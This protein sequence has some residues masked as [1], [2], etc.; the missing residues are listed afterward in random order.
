M[1]I[2][3]SSEIADK[4]MTTMQRLLQKL[5]HKYLDI[6]LIYAEQ[7]EI[8]KHLVQS[9][10]GSI[11]PKLCAILKIKNQAI[12][13]VPLLATRFEEAWPV[14]AYLTR[15]LR[16]KVSRINAQEPHRDSNQDGYGE[17][18]D[19]GSQDGSGQWLSDEETTE[20]QA[21]E[22]WDTQEGQRNDSQ[23]WGSHSRCPPPVRCRDGHIAHGTNASTMSFR[24]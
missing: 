6:S 22:D 13:E 2:A 20:E 15:Y 5:A 17:D 8:Q 4:H 7:C 9:L 10:V 24:P 11:S 1:S 3:K 12:Q 16:K 14:K 21:D 19:W 23:P 18:L